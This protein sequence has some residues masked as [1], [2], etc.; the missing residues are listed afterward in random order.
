[1][2]CQNGGVWGIRCVV[3]SDAVV[4]SAKSP[5]LRAEALA[6]LS[7]AFKGVCDD[8]I[9]HVPGQGAQFVGMSTELQERSPLAGELMAEAN[10]VLGYDLAAIMRDGPEATLTRTDISQPAILVHSWM[11]WQTWHRIAM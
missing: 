6:R 7:G 5:P 2:P 3:P 10:E 9:C 8:C 1:M 4:D 11:A